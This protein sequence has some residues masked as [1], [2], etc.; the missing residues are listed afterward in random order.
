M[1]S[2]QT[3]I[4]I[5]CVLLAAGSSQ[6]MGFH[7]ALLKHFG[8]KN[9]L[10]QITDVY[11]NV[12]IEQVIVVVSAQLSEILLLNPEHGV[13]NERVII[14]INN[15]PELGRFYSLQTGISKIDSRNYCFFQNIDN[16]FTSVELLA[17]LTQFKERAEVIIPVFEKKTGHPV[18]L[19]P[20]VTQAI[21]ECTDPD[22]RIN[23]FL[24]KRHV[25]YAETSDRRILININEPNEYN[26]S[27]FE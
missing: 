13:Q 14:C 3:E 24:R 10:Q 18:L 2:I 7:K 21:T 9:F 5:S 23:Q 26:K 11:V 17:S 20:I 19:S 1:G 4:P 16:P 22:I 27:G 12:G 6:R 8:N 15:K 25:Y